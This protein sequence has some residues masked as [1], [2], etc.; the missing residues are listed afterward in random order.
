MYLYSRFKEINGIFS[1]F[2]ANKIILFTI[3]SVNFGQKVIFIKDLKNNEIIIKLM[4]ISS[5]NDAKALINIKINDILLKIMAINGKVNSVAEI[6]IDI[7][8]IKKLMN[9]FLFPKIF[10]KKHSIF[11]EKVIIPRTES[12]ESQRPMLKQLFGEIKS[13]KKIE[14]PKEFNASYSLKIDFEIR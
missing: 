7:F 2:S 12:E 1:V 10:V 4:K 8:E 13:I 11:F 6:E 14:I 3:K 9:L 5:N